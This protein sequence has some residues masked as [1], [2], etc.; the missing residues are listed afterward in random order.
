MPFT[1][2]TADKIGPIQSINPVT[3]SPGQQLLIQVLNV[4]NSIDIT[5]LRG[6]I[7]MSNPLASTLSFEVHVTNP[8]A[9]N[10]SIL[11]STIATG[12][13]PA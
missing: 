12:V 7:Q 8:A 10:P 11:Q 5:Q 3:L 1:G 4:D 9:S 13:V 2:F 6:G